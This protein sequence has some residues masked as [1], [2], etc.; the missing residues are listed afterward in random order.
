MRVGKVSPSQRQPLKSEV[1]SLREQ[2][3]EMWL[4]DFG[5]VRGMCYCTRCVENGLL[6]K[7]LNWGTGK[8]AGI[9]SIV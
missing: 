1:K 3:N 2:P 6:D 5:N 4:L 9:A 7:S 8:K